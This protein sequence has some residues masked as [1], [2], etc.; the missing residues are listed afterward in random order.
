M[1]NIL[2]NECNK[3]LRFHFFNYPHKGIS[4]SKY[5]QSIN[6][7]FRNFSSIVKRP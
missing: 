6:K 3:L 1:L 5:P 2:L 4:L 7:Y